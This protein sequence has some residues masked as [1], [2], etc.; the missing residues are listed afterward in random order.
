MKKPIVLLGLILLLC[1][2]CKYFKKP[3]AKSVDTITADTM[4]SDQVIDSSAYYGDIENAAPANQPVQAMPYNA[5]NG[6]YY[7]IVGCFTVSANADRYAEK[8]RGM[9]YES[10]IISGNSNF[11]MVAARSYNSYRESVNE[12][13]KFRNDVTPNAWVYLQR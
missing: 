12:L 13:D 9:G 10:Q 3:A 7:M 2:G 4:A 6:K 1:A 11:Q 8:M 5:V